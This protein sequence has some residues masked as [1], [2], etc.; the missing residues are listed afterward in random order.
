MCLIL[1]GNHVHSEGFLFWFTK[2]FAIRNEVSMLCHLVSVLGCEVHTSR[3][4]LCTWML[5]REHTGRGQQKENGLW[6]ISLF[7]RN[8]LVPWAAL[9]FWVFVLVWISHIF[10]S[11]W[12]LISNFLVGI[13]LNKTFHSY[14]HP[15]KFSWRIEETASRGQEVRNEHLGKSNSEPPTL[16]ISIS[17]EFNP[18]FDT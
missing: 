7:M 8:L 12:L 14:S 18:L 5:A 15:L 3:W 1:L 11:F 6:W 17:S 16:K 2:S 13:S 10:F 9:P 4:M